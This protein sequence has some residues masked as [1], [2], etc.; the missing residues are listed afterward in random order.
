MSINQPENHNDV[1]TGPQMTGQAFRVVH[2]MLSDR[3]I[4][5]DVATAA[6]ESP[7]SGAVVSFSGVVRNHDGRKSVERLNYTAHPAAH[8]ALANVVE[9]VA[10]KYSLAGEGEDDVPVQIWAA[11]RV[12]A[13][14]VGDPAL[15]CA[16]AAGHRGQ[17]FAVSAELID[18]IKEEVPIWKEQFF[19]DG[20][21]EWVGAQDDLPSVP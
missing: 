17:A 14:Q 16:V 1:A 19:S 15:V 21:V 12:G 7:T 20:T 11:H 3:P 10:T 8:R 2:A 6:V 4:S 18:R 13:L 5:V 9:A